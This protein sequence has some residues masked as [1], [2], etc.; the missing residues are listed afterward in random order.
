MSRPEI[1]QTFGVLIHERAAEAFFVTTGRFSQPA[2]EFAQGKPIHLID[3]SKLLKM[4]E[5]ALTEEFIRS[6]PSGTLVDAD[7]IMLDSDDEEGLDRAA[8]PGDLLYPASRRS[9][10]LPLRS[11]FSRF[12]RIGLWSLPFSTPDAI[13]NAGS[14]VNNREP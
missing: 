13:R 14:L 8:V 11:K 7:T 2:E 3:L 4:S 5:G 9:S 1:Q 10:V 12:R 6:G